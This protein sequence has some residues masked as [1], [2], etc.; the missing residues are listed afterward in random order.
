MLLDKVTGSRPFYFS[1]PFLFYLLPSF[2]RQAVCL[3]LS[4]DF[5]FLGIKNLF[6]F[7]YSR[8]L[9]ASLMLY[10]SKDTSDTIPGDTSPWIQ[11]WQPGILLSN[12]QKCCFWPHL[13]HCAGLWTVSDSD[14]LRNLKGSSQGSRTWWKLMLVTKA[15]V[16]QDQLPGWLCNECYTAAAA[17]ELISYDGSHRPRVL[18]RPLYSKRASCLDNFLEI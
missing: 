1:F 2:V 5:I 16:S 15:W 17:S 11:S 7:L 10:Y 6:I 4:C 8:L 14:Y 18:Q 3:V 12:S 9:W 13:L